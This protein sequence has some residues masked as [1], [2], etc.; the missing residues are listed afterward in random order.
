METCIDPHTKP[1]VFYNYVNY[2]IYYDC[3]FDDVDDCTY[4]FDDVDYY[5][6][7]KVITTWVCPSISFFFDLVF[8][9]TFFFQKWLK[10][11]FRLLEIMKVKKV[12]PWMEE[13]P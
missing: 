7:L 12:H 8:S 2:T 1:I 10:I 13:Q 3:M 4:L 11:V 6:Y 5:T 9:I